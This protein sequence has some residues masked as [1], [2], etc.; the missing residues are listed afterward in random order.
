MN[1]SSAE[2]IA[3][4]TYGDKGRAY[5]QSKDPSKMILEFKEAGRNDP[6]FEDAS[7]M[8][9]EIQASGFEFESGIIKFNQ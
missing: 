4:V 1:A 9:Q 3:L 8:A 2:E 6:S 7:F 5:F